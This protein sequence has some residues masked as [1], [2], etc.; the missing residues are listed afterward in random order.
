MINYHTK[1]T[2][3]WRLKLENREK[4]KQGQVIYR[5]KNKELIKKR[6]RIGRIKRTYGISI[7]EYNDIFKKQNKKCLICEIK[8]P[9][10]FALN[11]H[12]DHDHKTGK[13]RGILCT[14][15]NTILGMANDNEEILLS[16]VSY[17]KSFLVWKI[18]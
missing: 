1:K 12:I 6:N 9:N 4:E 13:V 3:E 18:L 5:Q 15:C 10:G 2:R 14:K 8:L 17:L 7:G 16:A 11:K